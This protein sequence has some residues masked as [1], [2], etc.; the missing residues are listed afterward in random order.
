MTQFISE[1]R[2][3][4]RYAE[5]D[6]MGVVYHSNFFVWFEVGRVEFMRQLG[7]TYREL[8]KEHHRHL[9]VAEARCRYKAP[10]YYDEELVVRTHVKRVR[11]FMIHFRYEVLRADGSTPIAEGET[12]HIVLDDQRGRSTFPDKYLAALRA[13]ERR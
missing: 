2:L 10:A 5:T 11:N 12:V 7:L 6:Q 13:I 8:E 1:T 3:R 4:V 9:P